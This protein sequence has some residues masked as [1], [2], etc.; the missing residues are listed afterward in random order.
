MG[1][2][3]TRGRPSFPG[4]PKPNTGTSEP[5]KKSANLPALSKNGAFRWTDSATQGPKSPSSFLLV[6]LTWFGGRLDFGLLDL[7]RQIFAFFLGFLPIMF[8]SLFLIAAASPMMEGV[9][10][11]DQLYFRSF[12]TTVVGWFLSQKKMATSCNLNPENRLGAAPH[13][14]VQCSAARSMV[15]VF[16]ERIRGRFHLFRHTPTRMNP[17]T[18]LFSSFLS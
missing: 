7:C 9:Q 2:V 11:F 5:S 18:T 3:R 12:W 10:F 8:A 6:F 16:Y 17:P 1:W 4:S 13:L 14:A 15:R